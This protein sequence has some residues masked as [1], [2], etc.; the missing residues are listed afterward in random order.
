MLEL[1]SVI[2]KTQL[3]DPGGNRAEQIIEHRTDPLTSTVASINTVLG[4]K[5]R[6]FLGSADLEMLRDLQEKSRQGCPFCSAPE[7]GTRFPPEFVKEGQIRIGA[8]IAMPNL[9]SKCAFDS[10]VVIDQAGHDLFPSRIAPASLGTAVRAAVE[11]VRRARAHDP[12][13]L[14]HVAGMNFLHPG[15]SSVPH[16]HFQVHVRSVP[17]SGVARLLRESAAFQARAGRSYWELL[18]EKE[19]A[20]GL[21]WIGR[22]GRIEWLAAWA[23]AHQKEIWGLLPGASS[24]AELGDA[25]AEAFGAGIARVASCYE[26]G[27]TH[28]FTLAFFSSPAP[29]ERHFDLQVRL[30]SRP[31]FKALFANYDTWFTPKLIGDEV[32][33]EAPEQYAAR[34]RARW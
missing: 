21:R 15:G 33:T 16:P 4:E 26:E 22:T 20:T 13:L 27:G 31:A 34:L 10:V 19:R 8:S 30:C 7:K 6:A 25:D 9:F 24:L 2:E 32:H 12:S 18:L 28:P 1:E 11:L 23:P 17:Y 5:A 3:V 29:G 14:H